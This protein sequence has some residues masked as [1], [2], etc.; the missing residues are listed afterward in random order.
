MASTTLKSFAQ[1]SRKLAGKKK[2]GFLG[3]LLGKDAEG[4]EALEAIAA[5][6]AGHFNNFMALAQKAVKTYAKKLETKMTIP[7]ANPDEGFNPTLNP[8]KAAMRKAPSLG[9][10]S[11]TTPKKKA[12]K[13]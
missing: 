9:L 11:K 10:G 6:A 13:E 2:G 8:Q 7:F 12:K 4:L 1:S 3:K 5:L